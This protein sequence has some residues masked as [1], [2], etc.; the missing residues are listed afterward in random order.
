M[1]FTRRDLTALI[2]PLIIE[3]L[4]AITIGMA[5]TM[6]VAS[7]GEAAVSAVSLVDSINILLINI[8]SALATGGAVIASQ[9]LGR[10]DEGTACLAA[11]QLTYVVT[12]LSGLFMLF[13]IVFRTSLLRLLF[14][15]I[16]EEVMEGAKIYFLL[17]AISYPFLG[18]YNAGAALFRAMGN[19]K[20]SM[21]TSI[22]M[23][24]LNIIGN[25]ILIF[26]FHM[27]VTGAATATLASRIIGA[28]LMGVLICNKK[29]PI[30]IDAIFKYRPD[31]TLVKN[32][33][34]IGIPNG[35]ENGM[36][37]L[38]RLLVQSLIASFGTAAIAANAVGNNLTSMQ[39]LPGTAIGLAIITVVGR[40]IGAKS[41]EQAK[42]YTVMLMALT[43][44]CV[45][46]T[47]LTI[48]ALAKPLISLY[49]LSGET[50]NIA[51]E[52]IMLYSVTCVIFWPPSFALPNSFRAASD[53]RYP[54]IISIIS[55]WTCR[56]GLSYVF[57]GWM[58]MGVL[59]VWIAMV[60]DWIFRGIFFVVRYFRGKWLTKYQEDRLSSSAE[61]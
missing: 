28:V 61:A 11:K 37:Q 33:L 7:V 36:F 10:N 15:A 40:C 39:T 19:S 47:S 9:Y 29:N 24:G 16:D 13:S 59:G 20:V 57:G 42:R 49:G 12:A 53:A 17:S 27:G 45:L 55:M 31:F 43:H 8:F 35:L 1:L 51:F 50:S 60:C 23:N 46:I 41:K 2:I 6:M 18:L 5:D 34:R 38:G 56:I 48:A 25:A 54:M 26:V 44:I 3:Q 21:L 58:G 52:L 30:H 32:I 14:G 22:L 4:L